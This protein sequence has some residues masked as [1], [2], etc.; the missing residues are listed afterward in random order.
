VVAVLTTA[1]TI[2]NTHTPIQQVTTTVLIVLTQIT[3]VTTKFL[4]RALLDSFTA[5]TAIPVL[6]DLPLTNPMEYVKSVIMELLLPQPTLVTLQYLTRALLDSTMAGI[7]IPVLLDGALT[8]PMEYVSFVLLE[9]LFVLLALQSTTALALAVLVELLHLQA[10]H[11]NARLYLELLAVV[12]THTM[13]ALPAM[14]QHLLCGSVRKVTLTI[15]LTRAYT[16]ENVAQVEPAP[17]I[18]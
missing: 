7:A 1:L 13:V 9:L 11:T 14:L 15:C 8:N 6:L 3:L 5:L 10:P 17:F 2:N 18:V 4:T 16:L 12:C